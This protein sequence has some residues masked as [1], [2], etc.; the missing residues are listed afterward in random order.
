MQAS[1]VE[2]I[3][4]WMVPNWCPHFDPMSSTTLARRELRERI[5]SRGLRLSALRAACGTY[6]INDERG[7]EVEGAYQRREVGVAGGGGRPPPPGSR[8]AGSHRRAR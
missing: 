4:I 3:D 5:E 2:A 6:L 1:G 8:G 7:L